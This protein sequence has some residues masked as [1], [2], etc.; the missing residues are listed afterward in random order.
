MLSRRTCLKSVGGGIAALATGGVSGVG[1]AAETKSKATP[2]KLAIP[3]LYRGRVVKVQ[4]DAS[5]EKGV[6]RPE[7]IR[8]ML[9][10][11]MTGLTGAA[12]WVEAWKQFV[13]PGDVVG[14]KLNPVGAPH[15]ISDA[16]VVREVI[17]GLEAAGVKRKNIVVYDRYRD[18]FFQ[19]G[20]D[21][22]LPEGVRISHAAEK[23]DDI[24]QD[25]Q[26]YDPEHYL[27][28]PLTLP[29]YPLE[30]EKARRSYAARFIT[31]EVDKLINLPLLKDH[32]SAGITMALKNLSHGL[33]N[34]VA[35]SHGTR[36]LN[37]CNTFIPAVVAMPIIRNKAVLH[38]MDGVK[39]LYH[40]GPGAQPQFV[41]EH[42]TLYFATDPVAL[43]RIGWDVIDAKRVEVGKPKLVEDKPDQ[44]STFVHRQPEHVEIAG[45]LG[46]GEWDVKKI[47]LRSFKV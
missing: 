14:L 40:G 9:R 25:I 11:G 23:Y 24:Q 41:W 33:V 26:G 37:A 17:A 5:I 1:E 28:F 31:Q 12:D 4:G 15:V 36:S 43:D 18:Q 10:R 13:E 8:A 32:Q 34:N 39:G 42:K 16:S 6:Y 20:F 21:K 46:L 35:R 30:N 47:D 3:G 44:F 22:W 2:S 19:A 7:T 29:G 45:A 38:I 27:D